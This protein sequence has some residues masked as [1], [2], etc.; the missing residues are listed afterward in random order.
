[1]PRPTAEASTAGLGPLAGIRVLDMTR[2]IAGPLATQIIG[3]LGADVI[4]IERPDGGDEVRRA[5]PPW[6]PDSTAGGAEL[7]TFFQAV[8]R[9]KRSVAV[10]FE[11][12]EGRQLLQDLAATVDVF[13][14]NFRPGTLARYG[15]G[16]EQLREANP[17]LVYCSVTGFGQSGPYAS[18]SG[19]DYLVQGM[20][21]L[22]NVTGHPISDPGGGPMRVGIPVVDIFTGMNAALGILAALRHRDATGAGQH[23]DISLFDS[24]FASMLNPVAAWFNG[25]EQIGLTSNDHPTAAP[26][27]IFAVRD[28]YVI[29]APFNDREFVRLAAA[30]GRPEW[31]QDPRFA[32]NGGR[33]A[34]RAQIKAMVAEVLKD[35]TKREWVER[36]NQ[37]T[38]SC[39]PLNTMA[40]LQDDPHVR[41]RSMVAAMEHP[42]L[43]AVR[44]AAS[45][46]RLPASP[47]S[48]RRAP[49]LPGEHT[50]EVLGGDL[51]LGP[52]RIE[53]LKRAGVVAGLRK[54]VS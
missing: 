22:M 31:S 34:H 5:G 48:Y 39:G 30:L 54:L 15:L 41:E 26:Y 25:Q 6:M 3:D 24:G 29:I 46:L 13:V 50:E 20:A 8:N 52:D 32:T 36:L 2:V 21:G 35:G 14:E 23:V 11:S 53:E 37:A 1:V 49:P 18:R 12:L 33:I 44:S 9:N 38:V 45:P 4:K 42:L 51:D 19:Y 28:G 43:G 16:Y 27:G 10:S 7:S 40:D 47:V 17:G